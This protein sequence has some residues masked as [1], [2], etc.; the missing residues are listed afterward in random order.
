[1]FQFPGFALKGLCIQ[2]V[3][4][5]FIGRMTA[6][7]PRRST[8]QCQVGCP[9]R[10]SRDHRVLSPPPSLSQSATSFIASYRQGIHQTPF[11]RL[12]RSRRRKTAFLLSSAT[13]PQQ[14]QGRGS[15]VSVD[16]DSERHAPSARSKPNAAHI[17]ISLHDVKGPRKVQ[18]NDQ[19]KWWVWEDSNLR[20]YAYQAYA[21][22]T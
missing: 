4:T 11:S 20:P 18:T 17:R 15:S 21:L 19:V 5:C 9:I 8:G 12:I 6:A 14:G 1:M 16:L 10:R 22:T 13:T 3:S 7:S 2:P